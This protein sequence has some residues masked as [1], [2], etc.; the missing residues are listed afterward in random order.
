MSKVYIKDMEMPQ[1]CAE[2]R[3]CKYDSRYENHYC[4]ATILP[5]DLEEVIYKGI[6]SI[7]C[8]LREANNCNRDK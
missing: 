4:Y 2:C 5:L 6:K 7:L 3:F 1:K 8:P